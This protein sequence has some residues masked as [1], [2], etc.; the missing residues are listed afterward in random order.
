MREPREGLLGVVRVDCRQ[1]AEMSSVE[2]LEKVERLRTANLTNEYPVRTMAQCRSHQIGDRHCGHRLLLAE[3]HLRSSR[4]EP[5]EIR[6][7]D[8]GSR[9]PLRHDDS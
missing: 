7:C 9:S 2:R 4:L 5:H 6:L 3:R 8:Y 1:A